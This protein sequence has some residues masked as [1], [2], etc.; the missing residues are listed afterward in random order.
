MAKLVVFLEN[1]S[2]MGDYVDFHF[3]ADLH[4]ISVQNTKSVGF[5]RP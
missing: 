4:N 5:E 3:S 2:C 1:K